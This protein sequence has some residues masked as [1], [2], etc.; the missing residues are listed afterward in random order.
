MTYLKAV[1]PVEDTALTGTV[2]VLATVHSL[3][4]EGTKHC[5]LLVANEEKT[6]VLYTPR[7]SIERIQTKTVLR[8]G[9]NKP[10]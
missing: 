9:E 3:R 4:E 10:H 7:L 5:V 1:S 8:G 2:K 6:D